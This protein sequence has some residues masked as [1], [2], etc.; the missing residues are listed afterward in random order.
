M[1]Q[2][3]PLKTEQGVV[4]ARSGSKSVKVMMNY[5]T[6]HPVYGKY[7]R[8]RTRL[9][10][11]DENDQ[12]GVGDTVEIAE[13]SPRSKTKKWRLIRVVEKAVKVD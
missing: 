3:K 11:H 10:V 7:V 2:R 9:W 13:C 4:V 5:L 8:G 1:E 12:A 6:R